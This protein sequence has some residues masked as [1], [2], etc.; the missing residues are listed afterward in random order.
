MVSF[1]LASWV[2]QRG[3]E[4]VPDRRF[5]HPLVVRQYWYL[6]VALLWVNVILELPVNRVQLRVHRAILWLARAR[7][8]VEMTATGLLVHHTVWAGRH[9]VSVQMSGYLIFYCM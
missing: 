2:H 8:F 9:Q 5:L 4:Q 7:P 3:P 6:L 1:Q